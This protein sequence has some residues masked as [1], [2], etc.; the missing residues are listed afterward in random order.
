MHIVR[1]NTQNDVLLRPFMEHTMLTNATSACNRVSQAVG[2]HVTEGS[3]LIGRCLNSATAPVSAER[4]CVG[5]AER[6]HS[7]H[8]LGQSRGRKGARDAHRGTHV[9]A[10]GC[11]H[12]EL[13]SRCPAVANAAHDTPAIRCA[14]VACA[15]REQHGARVAVPA[16][17]HT[18]TRHDALA[19]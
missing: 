1:S 13:G 11:R 19:L 16:Q 17:E 12:G 6:S 10:A 9:V 15:A 4:T 14:A 5:N 2:G 3:Q 8:L 7:M 18:P